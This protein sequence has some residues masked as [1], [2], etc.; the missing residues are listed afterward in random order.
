MET[1]AF[2]NERSK[3]GAASPHSP[4]KYFGGPVMSGKPG[5]QEFHSSQI[6]ACPDCGGADFDLN[7]KR[8]EKTCKKCGA[9]LALPR[10]SA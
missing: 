7:W 3:Q 6:K 10:R 1:S 8:K 9:V 2:V 5:W 4:H